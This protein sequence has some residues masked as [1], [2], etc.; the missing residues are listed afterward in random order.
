MAIYSRYAAVLDAEGNAVSVREAL[1]LI[2]QVLD[3]SVAEHEVDLDSDSRFGLSWFAEMGFQEGEFGRADDLA[4]ARN[5]SVGGVVAAGF[6]T[7]SRGRFRLLRPSE[8]SH[9]WTPATDARLTVWD[10]V[11]HLIR[12]LETEGEPAAA[13][14]IKE[15]GSNAEAA[16]DLCY[17]LHKI[18]ERKKRSKEAASYNRLV[19]AW[20][21]LLRLAAAAG[22]QERLE[23]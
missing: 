1:S 12:L 4:R 5:T 10:M 7:S 3:E 23:V 13:R 19:V 22:S 21:E 14:V 15:L 17:L 8:L 11:H 6:A 2:N 16:R 18:C 20:P 9:T